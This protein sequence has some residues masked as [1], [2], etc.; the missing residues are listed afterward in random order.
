M[1]DRMLASGSRSDRLTKEGHVMP[2]TETS[3]HVPASLVTPIRVGNWISANR[4]AMAPMTNKQSPENG[5]LSDAEIEWLTLRARGGF[6]MVIT[7]AWAVAAE[8]RIWDGQAALHE[9]RHAEP[10]A[11]LGQAIAATSA[12]GIVQLIHGGTRATPSITHAKGI[13]ASAGES[14]RAASDADIE[15]LI[16]A[17]VTAA[18]RVQDAGLSGVEIHSAHGFLP[19]QFISRN[20]NTRTD[21][22]GGDL[23]GRS[24]FLRTLITAIRDVTGP[25]LIIGVRLTP[26]DERHGIYLDETAAIADLLAQDGIDYLHLSLGNALE[27]HAPDQQPRPLEV[28]RTAVPPGLPIIAAG[29]IWTPGD[30]AAVLGRGA[31]IVAL[32]EAAISNPDW[33]TRMLDPDWTPQRPPYTP[34]QLAAVGV[35]EPFLEYYRNEWSGTVSD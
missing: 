10:L 3:A 20:R 5:V 9:P 1:Q 15:Y 35:T 30:A 16:D 11:R 8:G 19:A 24:R 23:D 22:W 18:R 14:W 12:L 34:A 4:V 21:E 31:D 32:G 29:K 2:T 25:N 27:P 13:S 33:P 6:G 26:K 28:I 17:H 7:G